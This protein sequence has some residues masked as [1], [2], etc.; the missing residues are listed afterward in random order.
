MRLR[1]FHFSFAF[2]K[3]R[4]PFLCRTITGYS[5]DKILFDRRPPPSIIFFLVTLYAGPNS[6]PF[7]LSFCSMDSK[8]PI[9]TLPETASSRTEFEA[10]KPAPEPKLW[11]LIGE[12]V[13]T[14]EGWFGNFD[15][16]AMCMPTVFVKKEKRQTPFWGLNSK[17]PLS[18]AAVMG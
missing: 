12:Q 10:Y 2:E 3:Y 7:S 13:T 18:L 11:K 4:Y 15:W 14:R 5:R 8:E 6:C 16:K 9:D 17:L 1:N